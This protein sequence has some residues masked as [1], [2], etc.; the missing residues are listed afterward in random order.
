MR[1]I[2]NAF[3]M[4]S[5]DNKGTWPVVGYLPAT[6]SQQY[7]NSAGTVIVYYWFN[8]ISKYITK[9]KFGKEAVTSAEIEAAHNSILWG[10]PSWDNKGFADIYQTGYGMNQDPAFTATFPVGASTADADKAMIRNDYSPSL[11]G[12]FYKINQ[13]THSSERALL[14]D[15]IYWVLEV[16]K[17]NANGTFPAQPAPEGSTFPNATYSFW[18]HGTFPPIKGAVFADTGGKI[19]YNVLFCD[20]HCQT[21]ADKKSGYIAVRQRFPN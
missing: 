4:Y 12:R 14:A 6:A 17:P 18:R 10:C 20:G 19:A 11:I 1:Q 3:F 21:L 2:G 7:K 16:D 8:F 5:N 15:N 9:A 13:W